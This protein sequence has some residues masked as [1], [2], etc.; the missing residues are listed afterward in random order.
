MLCD[1]MGLVGL[2]V[3][4]V[5]RDRDEH[6][7]VIAAKFAAERA[8]VYAT[9]RIATPNDADRNNESGDGNN[10]NNA[11]NNQLRGV[12]MNLRACI[13]DFCAFACVCLFFVRDGI[14]FRRGL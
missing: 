3:Y 6:K 5:R 2:P 14:P 11:Y 7:R 13:C 9:S 10:N 12:T 4:D 1:L 8:A